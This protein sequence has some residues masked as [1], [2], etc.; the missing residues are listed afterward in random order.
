[1]AGEETPKNAKAPGAAKAARP[2]PVKKQEAEAEAKARLEAE[3]AEAKARRE[4]EE[5][6]AAASEEAEEEEDAIE[7]V[8]GDAAGEPREEPADEAAGEAEAP[9]RPRKR[10]GK[11]LRGRAEAEPEEEEGGAARQ[12]SPRPRAALPSDV[13]LALEQRKEVGARRPAFHRQEWFRYRRLGDAWRAPQGLQSKRRRHWKTHPDIV[14]IGYRGPRKARGLHPSGFR[15][16]LIEN[17][18]GLTGVDRKTEAVRIASTV[19][20]RKREAIQRRARKM[21]IRVLNWR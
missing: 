17:E 2:R 13:K 5:A 14:S 19:G 21:G 1:V 7:G 15:E 4:A 11:R 18:K 6:K 9:K 3:E 12:R 16:V 20:A 8:G 10:G